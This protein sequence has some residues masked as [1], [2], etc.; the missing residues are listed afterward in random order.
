MIVLD[1]DSKTPLYL[2]I[3]NQLKDQI[4]SGEIIAGSKLP[5]TR[6]LSIQLNVSR[7]TVE[8]AYM[9]LSSE[10]YIESKAGSGFFSLKLD[11]SFISNLKNKNMSSQK[12]EPN[13]QK[14]SNLSND[15]YNS[16]DNSSDDYYQY[17]F[18]YGKLSASDFPL[19]IWKRISNKCLSNLNADDMISYGSRTGENELQIE[20]MNY[21]KRSRGVTC[22]SEQIIISSG[23]GYCLSLLCQL[24]REDFSQIALED[25][26][27]TGAKDIFINNG[28]KVK[29]INL[30]ADGIDIN[31]LENSKSRIVYVTPSHQF[32][33]GVVIPI[34]K[35]LKLLDWA[36]RNQGIIIEDDYDSEFKYNS[37]PIPSIQSI[38]SN[39]TVIYVG[40]F[41]KALSPSLRINYMVLPNNL[42]EKYHQNFKMYQSPVPL[43]EQKII[44]QFIKLGHYERHLR[45][46][47]LINKRKYNILINAIKEFLG[48]NVTIHAQN[49]GLHILLEVNNGLKE[50][51]LIETAKN[52]SVRVYPVSL[53]W[54]QKHKYKDNM[55]L[56]GFGSMLEQD[57]VEGIKLLKKAWFDNM[58]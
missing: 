25:P 23:M 56:L 32:P 30:E 13:T 7:N 39:G 29:P 31:E 36:I 18:E 17:N 57:I 5:S 10:G 34:A 43:L 2:Q 55:V 37:K 6:K 38:D 15:I 9:Q 16:F 26:G 4:I 46:I 52:C 58:Y 49:A 54:M 8:S 41:S 24:L 27:Y 51:V 44:Q 11:N 53:F 42:L 20:I 3:Y 1:I 40:T 12:I 22:K 28:Y 50:K 35:R 45:K 33:T 48:Q 19:R 47:Y 14:N 21:L